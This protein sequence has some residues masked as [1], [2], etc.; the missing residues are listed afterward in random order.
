MFRK[1][2][3]LF[4]V[5]ML[6]SCAHQLQLISRN[7]SGNGSGVAQEAGKQVTIDLNGR[8]YIGTYV[9]DGMKIFTTTSTANATAT[10]GNR[11]ATAYG[12]G[13]ATSYVPGSG[14]GRVIATS[15]DDTLRCDFNF[16]DGTG[17]GY[18]VNNTG[19]EY[20]LIIH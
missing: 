4:T 20:D 8:N 19:N 13:Y 5:F 16:S 3:V 12:N 17:I 15:G 7:N 6:S 2:I 9:Y 11:T 1:L 14:N 18:C 10:S